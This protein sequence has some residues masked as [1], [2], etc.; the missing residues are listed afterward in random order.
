M[1]DRCAI[2][3]GVTGQDGWHLSQFLLEKGCRVIGTSRDPAGA[4]ARAHPSID[5]VPWDMKDEAAFTA[6][7]RA[8]RPTEIYN[9]A[10]YASGAAMYDDPV[11]IGD[12]NGLAVARM[13]E[14]IRSAD[15]S[16]RFC[17]ASSSELFGE[18]LESP[19]SETTTFR[20]RSPYGAAKLY[21]H[22]IVGIYRRRHDLFACSAILFNHESTRRG[23][24]FVT[25]KVAQAAAR[26]KLGLADALLLG[27][28][29]ARRDWGYS[30]DYVRGMW[31]MLQAAAADDYVLATGEAH[32]VRE[33]CDLA[34]KCV[35][36]DYRRY[37][38]ES[39]EAFRPSEPVPLVGDASKAKHQLCWSPEIDFPGLI[40]IMVDAELER[41]DQAMNRPR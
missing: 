20:P 14:A 39:A 6:L 3:T 18:P 11:G 30:G 27:N 35:G 17:Q 23:P 31:L 25:G 8:A 37:V 10:A 16:I 38:R 1:T 4:R 22:E 33:L 40:R 7:L 13:L 5:L 2:I 26:I 9:L 21:A 36:L 19:Q 32:S 28:L 29:D 41:L 24:G 12:I 15:P 34:F